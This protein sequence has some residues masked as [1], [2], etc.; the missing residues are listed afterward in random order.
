MGDRLQLKV[1]TRQML[2]FD[3]A[4]VY[5][6]APLFLYLIPAVLMNKRPLLNNRVILHVTAL[7]P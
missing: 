3:A 2:N 1:Y 7:Y 5:E 4:F 6:D